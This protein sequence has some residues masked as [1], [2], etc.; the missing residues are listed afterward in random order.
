VAFDAQTRLVLIGQNPD[1]SSRVDAE[2]VIES[3]FV[4]R[5]A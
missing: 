4:L 1:G 2:L 5:D 3:P